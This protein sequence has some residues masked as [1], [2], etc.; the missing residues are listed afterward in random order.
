MHTTWHVMSCHGMAW[1]G[2]AQPGVVPC[3]HDTAWHGMVWYAVA[4]HFPDWPAMPWHN[5]RSPR[6]HQ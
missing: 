1:H 5:T 4:L 3:Q 2:T 6:D